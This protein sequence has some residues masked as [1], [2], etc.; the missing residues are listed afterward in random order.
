[1]ISVCIPY[2][3]KEKL[4]FCIE[5]LQNQKNIENFE[6]LLYHDKERIGCPLSLKHLVSK[7]RND[8]IVF[9]GDDTVPNE[10]MLSEA[11]V[12]MNEFE[13]GWGLVG[14]DDSYNSGETH[15]SHWMGHKKLL[16]YLDGEF[17]H[18][19]YKHCYCDNELIVRCK[20]INRY[21]YAEKAKLYHDHPMV[22]KNMGLMDK[23]YKKVYSQKYVN[24]D[25]NLFI[26]RLKNNWKE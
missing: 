11:L 21:K 15:A 26:K 20:S 10:N 2:I 5:A 23:D 3:R 17:F 4:K 13:G 16:R 19:G 8:Y 18:T 1:M 24:M 14:F 22:Q 25:Y 6:V 7:S 12:K 9:I